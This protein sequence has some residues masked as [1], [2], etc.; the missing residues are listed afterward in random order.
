MR[1]YIIDRWSP[2]EACP[3][4][5]WWAILDR[6]DDDAGPY[7]PVALFRNL[8]DAEAYLKAR[9]PEDADTALVYDGCWAPAAIL[10][11][12]TLAVANDYRIST[13]KELSDA[14]DTKEPA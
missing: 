7:P 4:G 10:A 12:G 1:P 14:L 5:G 6:C 3:D 2:E 11:D 13:H 8:A 9:D